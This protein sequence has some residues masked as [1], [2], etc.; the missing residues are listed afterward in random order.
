MIVL[1]TSREL[2]V[3]RKAGFISQRALRLAGSMVEPGVSTWEID[4]EV[5][6]YIES[7]RAKPSFL[8][9]DGYPAST[10]ISVNHVVIHGIPK[11]SVILQ[12]GD[13]V[14]IDVGA[15]YEGHCL[16]IPLRE[17]QR[18]GAGLAGRH[19]ESA[20]SGH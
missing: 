14:G 1:K 18:R 7:Q 3:M 5:R 2:A 11:K 4:K 17:N 8:G 9:Y 13:I 19:R 15:Q 6:R 12:E 16:D 10:C 20:V